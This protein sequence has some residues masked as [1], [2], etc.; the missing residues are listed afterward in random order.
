M[1]PLGNAD[2]DMNFTRAEITFMW[3]RLHVKCLL[4]ILLKISN[5][6]LSR[7]Q[8]DIGGLLFRGEVWAGDRGWEV[9]RALDDK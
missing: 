2:G 8:Q 1:R 6:R 5:R 7:G 4:D 9:I 3:D